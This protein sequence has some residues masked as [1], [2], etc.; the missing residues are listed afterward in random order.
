MYYKYKEAETLIEEGREFF[1]LNISLTGAMGKKT[2]YQEFETAILVVDSKSSTVDVKKDAMSSEINTEE[3]KIVKLDEDNP[4]LE[5]P[6]INDKEN[7]ISSGEF[8]IYDQIYVNAFLNLLK[9]S[10]PDEDLL[11]EIIIAYINKSLAKSNDWLV[12]SKLLLQKSLAEDKKTKT[13][14]RSLL[15]IQSLCDQHNDRSPTP[16]NRLRY[17]F[18]VDYPFIWNIKKHNAEMF[19]NYGAVI[20]AFDIFDELSMYEE[21]IQCLYVAGKTQRAVEFAENILKKKED[22]GIYCVLGEI[23]NKEEYFF[24]ALEISKNKYTRAYRCL[25]KF[26]FTVKNNLEESIKYYEKAM[27]INPMFPN[28]WFTM[29]CIYLRMSNWQMAVRCFSKSVALDETSADA[30]ANLGLAF[31][32]IKKLKEAV[33]CLEEGFKRNRSW[34]ICENLMYISIDAKDL[35]KVIFAINNL[36]MLDQHE[37]L[38]PAVYYNLISLFLS[39]YSSL[40]QTQINFFKNQIYNIFENFSIK[41]GATPEI[42]DLYA[43][44]VES[45]EIEIVK[46]QIT[47]DEKQKVYKKICDLLLKQGRGLIIEEIW[48]KNE[49]MVERINKVIEK[50]KKQ[51][52]RVNDVE[53]KQEVDAFV[54]NISQKIDKFYRIK[55]FEKK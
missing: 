28:I 42:W 6:K 40:P 23:L 24:K 44:Y 8:S 15:Q 16:Y 26:F 35:N 52:A 38:K 50:L 17:I 25:G 54:H 4:L 1:K 7:P 30:W 37:R 45:V 9:K 20:T 31:A 43:L 41:D 51:S 2:K 46:N 21:C 27:E 49:K 33:K 55:E 22:P 47:D 29:G 14:E 39:N 53:Y 32:Q 5:T 11:R 3:P 34:K 18:A 36:F 13:I 48:E 10:N 19:M 12:H